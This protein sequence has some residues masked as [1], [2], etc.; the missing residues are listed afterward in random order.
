VPRRPRQP[1]APVATVKISKSGSSIKTS[2]DQRMSNQNAAAQNFL[3]KNV[4]TEDKLFHY[5]DDNKMALRELRLKVLRE[6]QLRITP[7]SLPLSPKMYAGPVAAQAPSPK[8]LPQPRFVRGIGHGRTNM[9]LP[10]KL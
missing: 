3:I 1:A 5:R 2:A 9:A 6:I 10:P 8:D 7:G 4:I